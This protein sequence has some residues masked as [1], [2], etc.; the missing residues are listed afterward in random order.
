MSGISRLLS[1]VIFLLSLSVITFALPTPTS[2]YSEETDSLFVLNTKPN[3]VLGLLIDLEGK[4]KEPIRLVA[5]AQSYSGIR[6]QVEVVV[7]HLE[8]CNTAVLAAS[9]HGEMGESTKA[10]IAGKAAAIISMI[11]RTCLEVSLRLGW[12]LVFGVFSKLDVCL[13]MLITNLGIIYGGGL[14]TLIAKTVASTCT[15]LLISLNFNQSTT[16]LSITSL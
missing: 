16:A 3:D 7:A 10:E 6:T 11:V 15:Q 14:V 8:A 13:K 4:I 9:K 1:L 2:S 5:E 12:F